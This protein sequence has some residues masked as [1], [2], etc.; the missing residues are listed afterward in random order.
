MGREPVL[1]LTEP[2]IKEAW[3]E[4]AQCPLFHGEAK[5]EFFDALKRG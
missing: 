5:K 3:I 4:E 1:E 2:N